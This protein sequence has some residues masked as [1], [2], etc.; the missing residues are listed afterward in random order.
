MDLMP[1]I[2]K[3]VDSFNNSLGEANKVH[4]ALKNWSTNSYPESGDKPQTLLNKQLV[5]D[6]D[7][8]VA[9]FWTKF[10]SPTD[11][12]GSGT[13]EEIE[14]MLSQKKQVFMYFI[15]STIDPKKLDYAQYQKV[16]DFKNN[17]KDRGLY[18][19]VTPEELEKRFLNDL[20]AHFLNI[21]NSGSGIPSRRPSSLLSVSSNSLTNDTLEITRKHSLK[22][23]YVT[24]ILQE[25]SVIINRIKSFKIIESTIADSLE[26]VSRIS[27]EKFGSTPMMEIMKEYP[28]ALPF[29]S[30]YSE[31]GII[32]AS[33]ASFDG[34]EVVLEFC[35]KHS[36]TI[37]DSFW[38]LGNLLNNPDPVSF[39]DLDRMYVGS[40]SEIEKMGLLRN[41]E[42]HILK[43]NQY[44]NYYEAIDNLYYVS[45]YVEN[46]GTSSDDDIDVR[47]IVEKGHLLKLDRFPKPDPYTMSD[48]INIDEIKKLFSAGSD[49]PNIDEYAYYPLYIPF[50]YNYDSENLLKLYCECLENVFCYNCKENETE[51]IWCFKIKHLKQHTKMYFPSYLIFESMPKNIRFEINSNGSSEICSSEFVIK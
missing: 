6:S 5:E 48:I 37:D 51:D 20:C 33:K 43:Y 49:D 42:N 14:I 16:Q 34:K 23:D 19:E 29:L 22:S 39:V 30:H 4:L 3:S 38:Y 26:R 17:Y 8:C 46:N 47:I 11:K 44:F 41:L 7:M 13:E 36:I 32:N 25:I 45:M 2:Q 21:F 31:D 18:V 12:Y 35:K 50:T 9:I 28:G 15:N 1:T 40:S 10:G 27:P 24:Q